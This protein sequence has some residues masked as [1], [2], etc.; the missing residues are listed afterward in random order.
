MNQEMEE[1]FQFGRNW[2]DYAEK[3]FSQER[4]DASK[5][6]I[7]DF[8]AGKDLHG[9][10]FLDIGCGSGLHSMAAWQAG[11]L[12]I[13]GFDYDPDSVAATRYI[14]TKT[15]DPANWTVEQGSV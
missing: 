10:S 3:N 2:M 15:G 14:R 5:K 13:H 1:R 9:L 7:L 11:A 4:V 6:H 8:I 12:V